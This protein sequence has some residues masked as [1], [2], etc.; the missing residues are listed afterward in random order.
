MSEIPLKLNSYEDIFSY[1]DPREYSNRAL[2]DD[3]LIEIK[4]ASRDKDHN[5]ELKFLVPKNKRNSKDEPTIKKRLKEHFNKHHAILHK[6]KRG[7]IKQGI[8]FIIIGLISMIIASWVLFKYGQANFLHNLLVVTF[9]PAGW[10][11]FWAGLDLIFFESKK[12]K[13]DLEF[14]EKMLNVKITFLSR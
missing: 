2:S 8:F 1:F 10:F 11:I 7:V 3:F 4:K 13:H 9:E 5:I 6:E 14:Y 12:N